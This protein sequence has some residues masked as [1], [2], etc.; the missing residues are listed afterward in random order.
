MNATIGAKRCASPSDQMPASPGEILPWGETA[1]ASVRTSPAP[2]TAR[3]PRWTRCQSV[4]PPSGLEYWHIG[5]TKTRLRNVA[6]RKVRGE[7]STL[8]ALTFPLGRLRRHRHS[9]VG[10]SS[11]GRLPRGARK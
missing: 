4:T 11:C 10:A 1:V 9:S 7:K 6:P 3:L 2:P 5:D 8:I